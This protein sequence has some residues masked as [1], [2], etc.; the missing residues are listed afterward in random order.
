MNK[1]SMMIADVKFMAVNT[2]S[3]A[4]L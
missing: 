2:W 3:R 1:P 4:N